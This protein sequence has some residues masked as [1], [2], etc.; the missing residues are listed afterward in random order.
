MPSVFTRI[1]DGELPG[2][3]VWKDREA[4]AFLTIAPIRDGHVLVVPRQEVDQWDDLPAAGNAH[5]MRV[6]QCIARAIKREFGCARAALMIAGF[7]IPHVHL[8]VIPADSMADLSFARAVPAPAERLR[9]IATR[10]RAA[11]LSDGNVEA[12]F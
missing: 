2:H 12:E 4:V 7:E 5:L 11:L 8:H 9:E 6:S 3:F 10:M 1:I